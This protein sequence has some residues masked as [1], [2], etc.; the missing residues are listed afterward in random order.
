MAEHAL[1]SPSSAHRWLT[2]AGS[3]AMEH[4]MPS[5]TSDAAEYGT[6]CH[7]LSERAIKDGTWLPEG[8][9]GEKARNGLAFT[10]DM[11]GLANI[12]LGNLS[13][14]VRDNALVVEHRVDF[15]RIVGVP[16]QF[17]TSDAVVITTD[18]KELQIHDAKF[19][20]HLVYAKENPQLM[21]Y[22]L[23][24]L[25]EF[26]MLGDFERVRFVIHQP[27]QHHLDEWDCS[28]E[29]LIKFGKRAH[30]AAQNAVNLIDWPH[31]VRI[32]D[33]LQASEE[34]CR[35]CR[36]AGTC[37]ELAQHVTEAV[38]ASFEDLT[39]IDIKTLVPHDPLLLSAKMAAT[40][41]IENWIKSVRAEVERELL[42]GAKV[43]GYKIVRGKQGNRKWVDETEVVR[44]LKSLKL[45]KD[46]MYNSTLISPTD[47]E[48]LLRIAPD[49]WQQVQPFITR[50]EGALSIAPE[51][52]KREAIQ[53]TPASEAF[54]DL[55]SV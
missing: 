6:A 36:A 20:Y 21:L 37:P 33:F 32:E 7:D 48:K 39:S 42:T 11:V 38:G 35:Y 31:E 45:G 17:G 30:E 1:L 46:Q 28:I 19:G 26:G 44:L 14:Y 12:Y 55:T 49:K 52:D 10:K 23:G 24:A 43:P 40:G 18:G 50:S 15:S 34:A 29:H 25:D 13:E 47:A 16:N 27:S 51:E 4:R 2:C 41:L 3:V 54:S 5:K 53:I 9:L 8:H 22:A